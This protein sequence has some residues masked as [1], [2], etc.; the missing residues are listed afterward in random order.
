MTA[1]KGGWLIEYLVLGLIW[2]SSFLLIHEGLASFTPFGLVFWRLFS[3]TPWPGTSFWAPAKSL[4]PARRP[5]CP[6][7]CASWTAPGV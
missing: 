6:G 1:R 3:G 4:A 5:G 2:G 7:F